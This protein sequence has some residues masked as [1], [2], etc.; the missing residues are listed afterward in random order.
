MRLLDF[1][2][3]ITMAKQAAGGS[4][5][6]AHVRQ[7]FLGHPCRTG[8]YIS[9]CRRTAKTLTLAL[10][11]PKSALALAAQDSARAAALVSILLALGPFT[12]ARHSKCVS[13][14]TDRASTR[15]HCCQL[16]KGK[17]ARHLAGT[18]SPATSAA[19]HKLPTGR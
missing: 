11:K 10:T 16:D 6:T 9:S 13:R 2:R 4:L 19:T 7:P 14:A 8:L 12:A 17:R 5:N 18:T 3:A 15:R 1:C